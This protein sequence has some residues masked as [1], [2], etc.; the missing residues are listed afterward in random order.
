MPDLSVVPG[1]GDEATAD[2][3]PEQLY[4][5]LPPKAREN[6]ERKESLERRGMNF[7]PHLMALIRLEGLIDYLFPVGTQ[8]R[9]DLDNKFHEAIGN[10]LDDAEAQMSSAILLTP[11]HIPPMPNGGA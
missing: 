6:M 4:D 11:G 3:T 5:M 7:P 10:L 8:Q 1:G 2:L 9:E